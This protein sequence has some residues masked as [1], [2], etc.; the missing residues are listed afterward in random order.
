MQIYLELFLKIFLNF[1]LDVSLCMYYLWYMDMRKRH[2][3]VFD[4]GEDFKEFLEKE[5]QKK[6]LS[7]GA[8][9]KAHLKKS[10]KYK[11]PQIV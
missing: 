3:V 5:S 9:V 2:I 7:V 8:Y 1:C 4:A 11:E 6:K 10:T